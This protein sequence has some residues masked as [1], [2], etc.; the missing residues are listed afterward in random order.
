MAE[1]T[2]PRWPAMKTFEVGVIRGGIIFSFL[3]DRLSNQGCG[4]TCAGLEDSI[5]RLP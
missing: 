2:R 5:A 4:S 1:P 3:H